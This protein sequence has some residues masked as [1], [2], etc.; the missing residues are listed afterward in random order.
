VSEIFV[1]KL[2]FVLHVGATLGMFGVIWFVQ[3]VH[4]PLFAR[5]GTERFAAYQ[6]EHER[7]TGWV[8]T[9]LMPLEGL[10]AILLVWWRPGGITPALVW[11][12]VILLAVI[13]LSTAFF[14]IPQHRRLEEGFSPRAHELLVATNWVRTVSWTSRAALVL[15]MAA[16]ALR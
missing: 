7:R 4:Y 1:A 10:T 14:Q 3:V 8:V 6:A 9:P 12:G 2:I 16:H 5:V 15:W 13:W 11:A